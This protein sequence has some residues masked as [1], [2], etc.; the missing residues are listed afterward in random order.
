MRDI[1]NSGGREAEDEHF[2]VPQRIGMS[3]SRIRFPKCSKGIRFRGSE[4]KPAEI[5]QARQ[6]AVTKVAGKCFRSICY[7][8]D[9]ELPEKRSASPE[10]SVGMDLDVEKF[11]TLF[12]GIAIVSPHFI[13]KVE[14]RVKKL[15]E[16]L[17]KRRKCSRNYEEQRI[18]I[19]IK[20]RKLRNTREDLL[21]KAS[22]AMARRYDTIIVE[23]LNVRGMMHNHHLSRD[24][25]DAWLYAFKLKLK[26]KA[27]KYERN[28]IEIGRFDLSSKMRSNCGSLK[29][30]L[31]LSGR[32]YHCDACGL[33]ID[34]DYNASKNIRR[35]GLIKVG[36]VRPEFTPVEIATSGL[37]GL[38]PFGR[39]S[40]PEAGSSDASADG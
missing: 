17:T 11:T 18:K 39:M 26:R 40:V 25:E 33:V 2:A 8:L 14:K 16:H 37:H 22:T 28:M 27:E 15:Q 36:P 30:G 23:G 9:R 5:S 4:E 7:E 32:I 21:D 29:T 12:N 13:G 24:M 34:R 1:K 31:K 35:M 6:L 19:Q 20:Y 38:Y 10:N 3:G